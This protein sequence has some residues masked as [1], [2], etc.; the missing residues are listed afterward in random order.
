MSAN[1][2]ALN[3]TRQSFLS[4]DVTRADTQWARLRGLLGRTR[5]RHDEGVWI[6]PSQG[7]HT[8]GMLFPI[9]VVYLDANCRVVYLEEQVRP[10]RITS[11]RFDCR[12]VLELRP[13]TIYSSSTKVGDQLLICTPAEMQEYWKSSGQAV[14]ALAGRQE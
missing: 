6:V 2:Y 5:L 3:I 12:S 11:V 4:L 10:M 7:I 1:M 9:D 8:I 14:E 13:K